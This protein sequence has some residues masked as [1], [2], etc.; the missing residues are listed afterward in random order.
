MLADTDRGVPAGLSTRIVV[1]PPRPVALSVL[2]A[3][4]PARAEAVGVGSGIPEELLRRYGARVRQTHRRANVVVLEVP[5]DR[6]EPLLGE[7]AAAGLVARAPK[8]VYPLL[9]QSVPSL[10]IPPVWR[11]G[12]LGNGTRITIVDTGADH[13][14]DIGERIAAAHNLTIGSP[15][16]AAGA[17]T[18]GATD[19][20]RHIAEYSSRG[21]VPGL[22]VHKPD[23]VAVGGGTTADA[24]CRYG[25]GVASARARSLEKDRCIVPPRYVRM[26][27]TSMAA[28]HVSG[29][30]ALLVESSRAMDK[31]AAKASRAGAV[32]RALLQSAGDLGLAPDVAGAGIVDGAR[33]L[34]ALAS[35][36]SVETSI[37][38][39]TA[40]ARSGTDPK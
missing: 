37:S 15:G 28:P 10:A 8:P 6:Q 2:P 31:R 3:E 4:E 29:L 17:I 40:M 19:K 27:G 20:M 5:A 7:L 18:V 24:S 30:C 16:C 39:S 13:H 34:A 14:P 22:S 11:S 32:R 36:R 35:R 9:N 38:S 21:P 1:E 25:I 12:F 33:A 23:V 26:S